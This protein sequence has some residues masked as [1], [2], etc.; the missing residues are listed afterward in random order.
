M[1][2]IFVECSKGTYI[3]SLAYDLGAA[4][5]TGAYLDALVRTRHG[6]FAIEDATTLEGLEAAF[7]EGTWH[8]SFYPPEFILAGWQTY[9]A[10]E[11]Q[12]RDIIQG[13]PYISRPAP[14]EN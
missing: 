12:K 2:Q 4:L 9:T 7:R 3:R 6:P 8:E 14:N 1:L 11:E 10:T 5:G 13:K